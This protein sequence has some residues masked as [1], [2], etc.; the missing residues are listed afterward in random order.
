VRSLARALD[1]LGY[2][3]TVMALEFSLVYLAEQGYI[4]IWRARDV[5]GFRPDRARGES[6]DGVAYAHLLPKGLWLIDGE[7]EADR[8]VSF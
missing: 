4:Q 6:G 1:L 7:I 2:S 5:P 3:M 8:S